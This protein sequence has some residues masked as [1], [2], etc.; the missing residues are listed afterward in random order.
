ME[1]IFKKTR[2]VY[3]AKES[4]YVVQHRDNFGIWHDHC[5]FLID[6]FG[7]DKE[8]TENMAIQRAK[9]LLKNEVVWE[10]DNE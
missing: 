8:I 1:L 7:G 9:T 5:F 3:N 10:S 4:S 2:V 6:S